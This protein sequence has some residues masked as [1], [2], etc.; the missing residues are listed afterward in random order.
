[1]IDNVIKI[2]NIIFNVLNK[3][4]INKNI[5][6]AIV[7]ISQIFMISYLNRKNLYCCCFAYLTR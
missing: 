7:I 4:L 3:K 5:I 2:L 1:M 6:N